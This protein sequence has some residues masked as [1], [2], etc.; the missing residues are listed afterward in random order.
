HVLL[1]LSGFVHKPAAVEAVLVWF[2]GAREMPALV[3]DFDPRMIAA[4][5]DP[6]WRAHKPGGNRHAPASIAQQDRQAGTRR[7]SLGDRFLR[8]LMRFLALR[9][10]ANF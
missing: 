4:L 1:R 2:A 5:V 3:P 7:L 9:R 6:A 10:V 8:A